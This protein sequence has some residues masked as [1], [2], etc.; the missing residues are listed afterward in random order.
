M[1]NGKGTMIDIKDLKI[2]NYVKFCGKINKLAGI[3]PDQIHCY[4]QFED[5]K[6]KI[7]V[8][9]EHLEPIPIDFEWLVVYFGFSFEKKKELPNERYVTYTLGDFKYEL[10]YGYLCVV[11]HKGTPLDPDPKYIH[12]IQNLVYEL[13]GVEL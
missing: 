11:Y 5:V 2:N 6:T 8:K 13:E 4:L 10:R 9:I 1:Y 3:D 7:K 12:Q